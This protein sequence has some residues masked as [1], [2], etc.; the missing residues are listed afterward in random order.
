ML[1]YRTFNFAG[2]IEDT[3]TTLGTE[4]GLAA[5]EE[6]DPLASIEPGALV[7]RDVA[8]QTELC[9]IIGKSLHHYHPLASKRP[10]PCWVASPPVAD[11]DWA[12][13]G[14]R[15]RMSQQVLGHIAGQDVD[16]NKPGRQLTG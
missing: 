6:I 16:T 10:M 12:V 5:T 11:V 1:L 4:Y 2:E 8:H 9:D 7:D 14:G 15:Y 13:I 3:R